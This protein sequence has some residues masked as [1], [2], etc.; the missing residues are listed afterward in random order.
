MVGL[1]A[2]ALV[3]AVFVVSD[4]YWVQFGVLT[5]S[6]L[7]TGSVS[8][9]NN[10]VIQERTP[11]V[12]RGRVLSMVFAFSY[13]VFPIGYVAAGFMVKAYGAQATFAAFTVVTLLVVVWGLLTPALRDLEAPAGA[14]AASGG[15]SGA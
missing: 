3:P 8:P 7:L 14:S 9:I 12:M 1:A 10:V 5:V 13:A 2:G 6:G 11:E 4:S 15:R